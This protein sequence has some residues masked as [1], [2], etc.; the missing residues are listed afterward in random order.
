LSVAHT[1]ERCRL[2]AEAEAAEVIRRPLIK[3]IL[4]PQ[5]HGPV[6][7]PIVHS[8]AVIKDGHAAGVAVP[9]EL[10]VDAFGGGSDAVVDD[11]RQCRSR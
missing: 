6:E 4:L 5:P 8:I 3:G 1:A 10:N 9:D 2:Q 7:F 11:V